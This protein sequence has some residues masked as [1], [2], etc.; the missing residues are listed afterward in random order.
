MY[1]FYNYSL[2]VVKIYISFNFYI[3]VVKRKSVKRRV[4]YSTNKS[5]HS[6]S[7]KSQRPT[8]SIAI[9]ALLL[10][11]FILPG[12]GSLIAGRT[13]VGVIQVILVAVSIPL[14]FLIIGI[15]LLIG[16]WIWGLVT[17]IQIVKEAK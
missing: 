12:L 7:K 4:K 9:V 5:K 10:N 3:Y 16:T 11:M 6:N 2:L 8:Q 15:P 1:P 17:G 14:L 13:K